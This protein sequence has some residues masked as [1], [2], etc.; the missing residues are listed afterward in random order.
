[1]QSGSYPNRYQFLYTFGAA[2]HPVHAGSRHP[3][4]NRET[5]ESRLLGR[6][7]RC[8][9]T[10]GSTLVGIR[11]QSVRRICP[12]QHSAIPRSRMSSLWNC[13]SPSHC[14]KER[15]IHFLLLQQS[16]RH[17]RIV[18]IV[19]EISCTFF[20]NQSSN[21]SPSRSSVASRNFAVN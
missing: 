3:S 9:M 4:P 2:P 7:P 11:H 18:R 16:I 20:S 14:L 1:M 5:F 17:I 6:P 10:V 15:K 19:E 8:C 13:A 12:T 21:P